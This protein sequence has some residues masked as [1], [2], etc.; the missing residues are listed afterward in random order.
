MLSL[1]GLIV[2]LS[3]SIAFL[4]AMSCWRYA[5]GGFTCW[6]HYCACSKASKSTQMD[7]PQHTLSQRLRGLHCYYLLFRNNRWPA[8][9]VVSEVLL[10]IF[11]LLK[12]GAVN[13]PLTFMGSVRIRQAT[14]CTANDCIHIIFLVYYIKQK[15]QLYSVLCGSLYAQ[16]TFS[17]EW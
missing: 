17:W 14:E 11:T 2:K 1:V 12:S 7:E 9:T 16:E 4:G 5:N 3:C 13:I 8:N 15:R 10:S 6:V